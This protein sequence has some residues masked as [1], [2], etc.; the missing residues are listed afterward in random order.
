MTKTSTGF[1]V[2]RMIKSELF[3]GWSINSEGVPY[4]HKDPVQL[5][6]VHTITRHAF[7]F[8]KMIALA[9]I[10]LHSIMIFRK[11]L[12]QQTFVLLTCSSPSPRL[13]TSRTF[14]LVTF[15]HVRVR[16]RNHHHVCD[17]EELLSKNG[18]THFTKERR[19]LSTL[20][21]STLTVFLVPNW[22]HIM[23]LRETWLKWHFSVSILSHVQN[24]D[25]ATQ[26]M[27]T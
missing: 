20:R 26:R 3:I 13:I 14:N 15:W 1:S 19:I 21:D 2:G 18:P 6:A 9:P 11:Y 10:Q 23:L 5:L 16:G 24:I 8:Y 4:L 25:K 12:N 7:S 17:F 27:K 22:G